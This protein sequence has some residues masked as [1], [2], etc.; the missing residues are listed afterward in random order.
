VL[1][2]DEPTGALDSKTGI[3]VLEAL[4]EVNRDLG[5]ATI[6]ITHNADIQRIAERVVVLADGKVVRD[7]PTRPDRPRAGVLVRALDRKMLRDLRQIWA[8]TLAIALVLGCGIMLMVG[9]Q[10]T[11]RSLSRRARPTTN[12]SASPIS[13]RGAI[14]APRAL[15][16]EIAEIDGVALAEGRITFNAVLDIDGMDEPATARVLSLPA[17]GAPLLNVPL[18]RTGRMPDPDRPDEVLINEPFGEAH[19]LVPGSRFAAS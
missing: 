12:A 4:D 16:D 2:C 14:R 17:A 1:L 10:G 6:L 5:T 3:Q 8:Q 13:S 7:E 11:Q 15:L 9:A 19:D 18:L